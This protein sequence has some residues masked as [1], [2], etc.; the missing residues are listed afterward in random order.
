MFMLFFFFFKQKK[1]DYIWGKTLK[2]TYL[3]CYHIRKS[4]V[5]TGPFPGSV[6]WELSLRLA[7]IKIIYIELE[8]G[9]MPSENLLKYSFSGS[10][11]FNYVSH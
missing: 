4:M 10:K 6:Q 2:L 9:Q 7:K 11:I 1:Q 8:Q 5:N 3:F